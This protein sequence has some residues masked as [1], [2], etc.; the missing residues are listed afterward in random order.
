MQIDAD[1]KAHKKGSRSI[2]V[3]L[4]HLMPEM[5]THTHTHTHTPCKISPGLAE[6]IWA[7]QHTQRV[8]KPEVVWERGCPGRLLLLGGW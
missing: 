2:S 3:C 5:Q 6:N 1:Y 8:R 4:Q 7:P